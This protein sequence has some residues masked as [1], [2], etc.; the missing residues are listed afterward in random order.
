M[1]RRPSA[2]LVVLN[3]RGEI[4]LFRFHHKKGALAG[5]SYWATP[6]GAVEEGETFAEAARRE[7]FEETGIE[8]EA[9]GPQIGERTFV[10]QL[11]TGEQV[12][13]EERFYLVRA[14]AGT[15]SRDGWTAVEAEVMVGHRWWS[16][17]EMERT[18]EIIYPA[19]LP[20]MLDGIDSRPQ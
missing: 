11:D 3:P 2:R 16:T 19:D 14:D 20:R 8:V 1:H 5:R 15:L 13:A 9:V 10:L 18:A 7:L 4:L 6:G 12:L 17:S